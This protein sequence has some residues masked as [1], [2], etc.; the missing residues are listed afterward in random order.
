MGLSF[1]EAA[2]AAGVR[3]VVFSS[4]IHPVIGVLQN[5]IQKVGGPVDA[6]MGRHQDQL[7]LIFGSGLFKVVE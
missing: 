2:K 5:H 3:R 7:S 6:V 1:I 4:A